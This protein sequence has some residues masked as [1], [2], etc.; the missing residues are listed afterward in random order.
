MIT[1]INHINISVKDIECSFKFY[2][3]VLGF[4][5]LCKSEG[6][7]YFLSGHPDEPGGLW[8]SLD[9][10]RNRLRKPSPCNTHFAFSVDDQEFDSLSQRIIESRAKIFKDNTSIGKSLYF[11]D[12]DDHKLE[13]HVG[14]WQARISAKKVNPGNWKYVEWFV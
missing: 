2:K 3:D 7:A 13:I 8:F 4:K 1:G 12:P 14:N 6:S 10:D 5:P 9:L 11:L